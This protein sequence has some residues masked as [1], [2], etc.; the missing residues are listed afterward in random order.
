MGEITYKGELKKF[1]PYIRL[2]EYMHV[3]KGSRFGLGRYRKID[4]EGGAGKER[5]ICESKWW[6]G[7]KVGRAEIQSL[8]RKGEAVQEE[9]GKGLQILRLWFFGHDGL[10]KLVG[11]RQL[12]DV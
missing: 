7:R 8:I 2:G 11:L 12:P 4:V 5:W 9:A 3:G 10:L 6:Q 1:W